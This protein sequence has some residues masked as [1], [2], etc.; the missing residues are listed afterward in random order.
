MNSRCKPP[1]SSAAVTSAIRNTP[2]SSDSSNGS[3]SKNPLSTRRPNNAPAN[4]SGNLLLPLGANRHEDRLH[5][6]FMTRHFA[7]ILLSIAL[8][9]GCLGSLNASDTPYVEG[10]TE[11]FLDV[12]L[13]AS[14]AGIV[15]AEKFKEGD[16]VKEGDVILDLDKKLEE[17]E[18]V[19]RKLV[20]DNKKVDY[21]ATE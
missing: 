15:T 14:V 13:S 12:T 10:I 11:P 6:F 9:L 17:L 8:L 7:S 2:I 21:D 3:S 4:C 20:M 19:R 5:R 1:C 18:T 16:F